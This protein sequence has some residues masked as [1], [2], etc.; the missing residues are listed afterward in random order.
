H[1]RRP[2]HRR[3]PGRRPGER[4]ARRARARRRSRLHQ[5]HEPVA[6]VAHRRRPRPL[7]HE[8]GRDDRDHGRGSVDGTTLA[9]HEAA[10]RR[11][12]DTKRGVTT[13]IMGEGESM[14]PLSPAMKQE[15]AVYQTD[16]KYPVEWTTLREYLDWLVRRGVTPNVGSFIGAATPRVYVLGRE[17]RAPSP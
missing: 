9:R 11:L 3:R 5:C 7:R 4:G 15:S 14:G 8:A 12:S 17:N 6:G 2:H 13:G 10:V 16:I 1:P